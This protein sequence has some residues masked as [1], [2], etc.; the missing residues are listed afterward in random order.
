MTTRRATVLLQHVRKMAGADTAS[1]RE[2]L[3]RFAALRDEGAFAVLLQRHGPMVLRVCRRVLHHVQ[4]AEDVFQAA[5]LVLARKA[6][7]L[8][9]HESVGGWL[10]EVA[11]RLARKARAGAVRHSEHS[12]RVEQ[13]TVRD[14][15][16]EITGRE[17]LALLDTELARLP[18]R[19]RGP[20]VLCCLE[21]RTR[22][23]A[24]RQ[25]GW[26][27][28]TVRR[29]LERGRELLRARLC[30]RGVELP[31]VLGA[32]LL[33]E[34]E[35]P[36]A[37]PTELVK[38]TL[39]ASL[40]WAAG[41]TAVG[42]SAQATALAKGA[43]G[44][45][46]LSKLKLLAVL[47]TILGAATA[48]A[49]VAFRHAPAARQPEAALLVETPDPE[50][51]E[52]PPEEKQQARVDS[53]GDP[54]PPGAVARMGTVRFRCED[55]VD[56]VGFSLDGK[57]LASWSLN[58]T[59]SISEAPTGKAVGKVPLGAPVFLHHRSYLPN[60][61]VLAVS[62]TNA[63]DVVW[64]EFAKEKR[65]PA[66]VLALPDKPKAIARDDGKGWFRCCT[67]S[68]DGK[69]LAVGTDGTGEKGCAIRLYE[70]R[71]DKEGKQL[72]E[73]RQLGDHPGG[74]A[75]L[76]FSPDGKQLLSGST[77]EEGKD[78][79]VLV[80]DVTTGKELHRW[81]MPAVTVSRTITYV[82]AISPDGTT[83]AFGLQ[84]KTVRLWDVT[85]GKE[86]CRL[87]GIQNETECVAFSPDGTKL[88]TDGHEQT[89]RLWEVKTGKELHRC[90]GHHS[91]V[92][93]VAFSPDGRTLASGSSGGVIR[94]WDTATGK[95]V[96]PRESHE[97]ETEVIALSP[98]GKILATASRGDGTLRLWDVATGKELRRV[99]DPAGFFCVAFS[100]DGKR[101]AAVQGRTIRLYET[102]TGR[103]L[104]QCKADEPT[105]EYSSLTFSPD[106]K[107][108]IEGSRQKIVRLWDTFTG[109]KLQ[110]LR[111][112]DHGGL[113]DLALSPDGK[114]LGAVLYAS[115]PFDSGS[116]VS[117]WE[118]STGKF[119]RLF[120]EEQGNLVSSFAFSPDGKILATAVHELDFLKPRRD[121]GAICLWDA[122]TGKKIRSFPRKL[123]TKEG[124]KGIVAC[125]A[126]SPDGRALVCTEGDGSIVLYEV[127]TGK[128]RHKFEGHRD[129]VRTLTFS[130]DGKVLASASDDLT[131]LIWD[132]TGRP[133]GELTR[134]QLDDLWAD[135][136]ETDAA[137]AYHAVLALA[138]APKQSVG[139]LQERLR[140]EP[141]AVDSKR[142]A[143]W[144]AELDSDQFAVR[145]KAS[146][147]LEKLGEIAEPALRKALKG[148]PSV[149]LRRRVE[150]L[151][152]TLEQARDQLPT[153]KL[154]ALRA[155][156]AL[157]RAG[158]REARQALEALV[159]E[160]AEPWLTRQAQAALEH[161]SKLE[162]P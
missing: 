130:R 52:T 7:S 118:V 84:D 49:G 128:M 26:S 134:K 48:G 55:A 123:P 35:V 160:A 100:P 139:L 158:T 51:K 64:W 71:A 131:A 57:V 159:K 143:Q 39:E 15:L 89:V 97:R 12:Q 102:A 17:L 54:L 37:L 70:V 93:C 21:G 122:A 9:W 138:G 107:R 141:V 91:W 157:E 44:T 162:T 110:R 47:A 62:R 80:S 72:K 126:F 127:A 73:L 149:E 140:Q 8:H 56:W 79:T 146:A 151:L 30:G 120:Q 142:I 29:R 53:Y 88:A 13:A 74:V 78:S 144:L 147:E 133:A 31:M 135:L 137:K 28:S 77:K 101:F 23:E 16:D 19:Y 148:E 10:H 81:N 32:F 50:R 41:T 58:G 6:A 145:E 2:L 154:R 63:D 43:T 36:A 5:F 152:E 87:R 119:I 75:W 68:A 38:T 117:Q 3:Q 132:L 99:A 46:G 136:A 20:V 94:L 115:N 121:R 92:R 104:F 22:D 103:E 109:E 27:V 112:E 111:T 161:L 155:V 24:A 125:V 14:P 33:A 98:D 69:T 124:D 108:L 65:L 95:E 61:N 67:V 116:T 4:D 85:T 82:V 25:L 66:V 42:V 156:E 96:S 59:L 90:K 83:A 18:E 86:L 40:N 129:I 1:D 114:T 34:G 76:V 60:G 105:D 153:A 113:R 150:R 11:H 45:M 106:G